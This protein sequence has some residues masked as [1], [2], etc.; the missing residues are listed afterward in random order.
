MAS[1][2]TTIRTIRPQGVFDDGRG[3]GHGGRG[4][5]RRGRGGGRVGVVVVEVVVVVGGV[6]VVV[7]V[8][9]VVVVAVSGTV[10]VVVG[11]RH[12]SAPAGR[13]RAGG[14][15]P[16]ARP[17]ATVRSGGH[18]ARRPGQRRTVR[19]CPALRHHVPLLPVVVLEPDDVVLAEVLA[20]LDLDE[21]DVGV[22]G[23]LDAV[24][25]ARPGCRRRRPADTSVT[26]PSRVTRPSPGR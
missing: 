1:T 23:V 22:R 12:G 21:D 10:V 9:T 15:P 11:D 26:A 17:P 16:P 19:A 20:V 7:V 13:R 4:G 3:R 14:R 25:G 8:A 5:R 18:A 6:V 2:R 24:V